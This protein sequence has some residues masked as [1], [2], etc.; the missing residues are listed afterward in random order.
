MKPQ[1]PPPTP[2]V[3]TKRIPEATHAK[4]A[5]KPRMRQAVVPR[6]HKVKEDR[7][8]EELREELGL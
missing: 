4:S 8:F 2:R 6:V 7:L 1:S 5:R 3:K